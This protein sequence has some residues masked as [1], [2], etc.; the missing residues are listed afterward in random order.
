MNIKI[1]ENI[2]FSEDD[3]L[4]LKDNNLKLSNGELNNIIKNNIKIGYNYHCI[5]HN[6]YFYCEENHNHEPIFYYS[7]IFYEM[8]YNKFYKKNIEV[9]Y[10]NELSMETL[11]NYIKKLIK[12]LINL[13]KDN[14][15]KI[16]EILNKKT[17][18]KIFDKLKNEYRYQKLKIKYLK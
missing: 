3:C 11:H 16:I 13:D 7:R 1:Y 5:N 4:K 8:L 18:N 12:K 15:K 17:E 2:Y 10:N 6:N 14:R 9:E